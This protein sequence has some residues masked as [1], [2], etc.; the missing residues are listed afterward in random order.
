M[1]QRDICA[2]M[3]RSVQTQLFGIF[4]IQIMNKIGERDQAYKTS[5]Y[6]ISKSWEC[7]LQHGDYS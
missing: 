2:A 6:K 4:K 3:K 1:E 5:S 7:N